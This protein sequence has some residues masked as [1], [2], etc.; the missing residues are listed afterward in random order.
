[1]HTAR[2]KNF[3]DG[4][5]EEHLFIKESEARYAESLGDRII[6]AVADLGDVTNGFPVSL[7]DGRDEEYVVA[8][9]IHDMGDNLAPFSHGEM[10]AAIMKP[11]F[12]ERMCWVISHHPAFQQFYYGHNTGDDPNAR[13]A[14]RG[15]Q[16]FDD[17]VEFCERYDAN[18]FDAEYVSLPLSEFE[19]MVRRVFRT[20]AIP[21]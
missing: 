19:P 21:A 11:Y 3:G 8:A 15:H 7:R 13:E 4:T 6:A 17:C 16:W 20:P 9:L 2:F 10:I 14:W 18:C 5:A 12:S 1:M